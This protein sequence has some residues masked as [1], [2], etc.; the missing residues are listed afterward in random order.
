MGKLRYKGYTGSVDYSEEEDY[1]F[2]KVL[3]LRR[4]CITYEGESVQEIKKD[5][6]DA[7]DHYLRNCAARGVLPEKPYN[8]K[9][10]IRMP[11]DLHRQAAEQAEYL[12]ISIND[13]INDAI[14][15]ALAR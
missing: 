2:G 6:E 14:R 11:S 13:F 1:L 15:S 12:G 3:G 10:V 4:D 5:F 9:F 8:G 7:I